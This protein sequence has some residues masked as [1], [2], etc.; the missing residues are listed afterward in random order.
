MNDIV[1]PTIRIDREFNEQLRKA[2]DDKGLTFQ[3]LSV[4]LLEEWLERNGGN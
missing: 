4:K 3:E 1:R 2:L